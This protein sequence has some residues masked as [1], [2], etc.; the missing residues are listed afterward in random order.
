[1]ELVNAKI[2]AIRWGGTQLDPDS[3]YVYRT[4]MF[5]DAVVSGNYGSTMVLGFA[6]E[7]P[8]LGDDDP[9]VFDPPGPVRHLP[10]VDPETLRPVAYGER[11]QVVANHVSQSF[12]LPNNLERDLATRV[13][14][15]DGGAGDSVADI[16][17]VSPVRERGRGRGG[18][19]MRR[20][21]PSRTAAAERR[22]PTRFPRARTGRGALDPATVHRRLQVA[23]V[24]GRRGR[25]QPGPRRS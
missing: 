13:E 5:P 24:T 21:H 20:Q 22:G 23:D 17:P 1:M 7:R 25:T 12:L 8:G 10:V 11:G 3:R 9:C 15:L 4:E 19:L 14:P 2:R 18:L 6:G 16:A